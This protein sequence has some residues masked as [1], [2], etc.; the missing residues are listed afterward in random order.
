VF[1]RKEK[2]KGFCSL[3]PFPPPSFGREEEAGRTRLKPLKSVLSLFL[4]E[5]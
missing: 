1:K 2:P 5:L 4:E 3:L